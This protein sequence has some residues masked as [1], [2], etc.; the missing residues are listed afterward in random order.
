MFKRMLETEDPEEFVKQIGVP[1]LSDNP[2]R[3]DP[4][5][6][7]VLSP[8]NLEP[9]KGEYEPKSVHSVNAGMQQIQETKMK[10]YE[11]IVCERRLAG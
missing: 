3:Q 11:K 7:D 8:S 10:K 4:H 5:E 1:A 9:G 2:Q 6:R